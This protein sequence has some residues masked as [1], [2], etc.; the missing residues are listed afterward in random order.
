MS[1]KSSYRII[2]LLCLSFFLLTAAAFAQEVDTSEPIVEPQAGGPQ[3]AINVPSDGVLYN[4]RGELVV[5]ATLSN[6]G[7]QT[8]PPL[9]VIVVL[10][11]DCVLTNVPQTCRFA[12]FGSF[13]SVAP[14]GIA[15]GDSLSW[16]FNF[17]PYPRLDLNRWT[18]IWYPISSAQGAPE[19]DS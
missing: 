18:V 13:Q 19:T 6:A 11:N 4:E 1:L 16:V 9:D 17:G 15:P 8:V 14:N 2:T 10:L 7:S 3:V 12:A 5:S